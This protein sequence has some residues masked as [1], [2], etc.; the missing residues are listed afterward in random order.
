LHLG[1]DGQRCIARHKAQ[2]CC[3]G[4]RSAETLTNI[5]MMKT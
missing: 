4:R 1:K 2:L 5:R 3:D